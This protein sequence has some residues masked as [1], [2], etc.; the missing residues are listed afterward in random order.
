[1]TARQFPKTLMRGAMWSE[2][3]CLYEFFKT[4]T[5]V[6]FSNHEFLTL[7]RFIWRL[8]KLET[9]IKCAKCSPDNCLQP[10]FWL[11]HFDL[12]F[13]EIWSF[14]WSP[15]MSQNRRW[16]KDSGTPC[17]TTLPTSTWH[18]LIFHLRQFDFGASTPV[19]E[20]VTGSQESSEQ[21]K[22]FYILEIRPVISSNDFK[23]MFKVPSM[24]MS[25]DCTI[26]FTGFIYTMNV[27]SAARYAAGCSQ[28]E[29]GIAS[30]SLNARQGV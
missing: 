21:D 18:P 11:N 13:D 6:G 24:W 1:M 25:E 3:L 28:R 17:I 16:R 4:W 29:L 20:G 8:V 15:L 14:E 10:C 27:C 2:Q 19:I 5:P 22:R 26:H 23:M 9:K 7:R 12:F 30:W